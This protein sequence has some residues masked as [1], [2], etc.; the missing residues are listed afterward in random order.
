[1]SSGAGT[2]VNNLATAMSIGQCLVVSPGALLTLG[3][4]VRLDSLSLTQPAAYAAAQFHSNALCSAPVGSPQ[5]T[6]PVAGDGGG[7]WEILPERSVTVPAGAQSLLFGLVVD[8]NAAQN[9]LDV[10]FDSLYARKPLP[11][12]SDGFETGDTSRWSHAQP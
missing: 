4:V 7:A 9:L 1:V 11:F 12:F 2:F 5:A 10:D 8:D 6:L 3:G